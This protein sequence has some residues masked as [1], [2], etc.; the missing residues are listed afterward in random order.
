LARLGT[1]TMYV[2]GAGLLTFLVLAFWPG[3]GSYAITATLVAPI[4]AAG[5]AGL[6][7][8]YHKR[9]QAGISLLLAVALV[10]AALMAGI[11]P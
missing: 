6:E 11:S 9:I 4:V 8:M 1:L 3:M 10:V 2:I 5:V 7:L